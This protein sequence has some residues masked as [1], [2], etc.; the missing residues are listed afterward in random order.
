MAHAVLVVDDDEAIRIL[1]R[2]VLTRASFTVDLAEDGR[3]AIELLAAKHYDAI[4]VDLMMSPLSG[5]EVLSQIEER[6]TK[7]VVLISAGSERALTSAPPE[8][9][10]ARLRKPF[11]IVDQVDAVT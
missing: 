7:C 1:I 6:R 11:D 5:L 4:V 10:V 3:T 2:T 9:I 8:M